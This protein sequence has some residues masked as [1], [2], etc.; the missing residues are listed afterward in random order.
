MFSAAVPGRPGQELF[1]RLLWIDALGDRLEPEWERR[2]RTGDRPWLQT[3]PAALERAFGPTA[4]DGR[5]L[6]V[7]RR[8]PQVRLLT[9][10]HGRSHLKLWDVSKPVETVTR[11]GHDG[12][13]RDCGFSPDGSRILSASGDRTLRLWEPETGRACATLVGHRGPATACAFRPDGARIVSASEDRTLVVWDA[14]TARPIAM[15]PLTATAEALAHHPHRPLIAFGDVVGSA[16]FVDSTGVAS[17]AVVLTA[18][19]A[20]KGEGVVVRCPRCQAS[21]RLGPDALGAGLRWA[22][23]GCGLALAVNSFVLQTV[24]KRGLLRWLAGVFG[25]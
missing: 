3:S 22:G 18:A 1:N 9:R 24:R 12:P 21:H 14:G 4:L 20:E 23:K 15:L 13:L 7:E 16:S 6:G 2:F 10:R 19:P 8:G 25:R 11:R 17:G 5:G